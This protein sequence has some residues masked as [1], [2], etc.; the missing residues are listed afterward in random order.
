MADAEPRRARWLADAQAD[1]ST[2]ARR[3]GPVVPVVVA[4]VPVRL[5]AFGDAQPL[6]FDVNAS[7]AALLGLVPGWDAAAV[8]AV[9]AERDRAP[10]AS[11]ADLIARLR[12][13]RIA[14]AA[15][16]PG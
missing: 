15:L 2:L 8:T 16:A 14:R 10:F 9:L 12:A 11:Y 7:G 3:L 5:V 13:R 6:R 4:A 1:P